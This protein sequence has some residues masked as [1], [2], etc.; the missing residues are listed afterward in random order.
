MRESS[1]YRCKCGSS[2]SKITDSRQHPNGKRRR[3]VCE[4]CGN[5]VFTLE[6]LE[7]SLQNLLK[8]KTA[9]EKLKEQTDLAKLA[10]AKSLMEVQDAPMHVTPA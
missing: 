4:T 10:Y 8:I 2:V 9:Y 1:G 6:I 3:R 5:K 7:S